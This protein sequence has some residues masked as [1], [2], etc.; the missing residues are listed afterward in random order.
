[1]LEHV[2]VSDRID[3]S[4]IVLI[5]AFNEAG[6]LGEVVARALRVA[7][8]V[9]VIDDG[10]TD[11]TSEVARSLG[12]EVVRHETNRGKG[13]SLVSGFARAVELGA[14]AVITLDADGQHPPE[15]IPR[16][17]DT[18]R[19]TGI[20]ILVGNRMA[21][22]AEMPVVRR[23]TNR[24]MS[25]WLSR[26]MGIYMPDTQCGFRLYRADVLAFAATLSPRFAMESEILLH[27]ARR[28]F[29]MGS[30]RIPTVYTGGKSRIRPLVD[31]FRFFSMLARYHH[32]QRQRRVD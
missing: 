31:A 25:A 8:Q 24:G 14:A 10:S 1:M 23:W 15:E 30:V 2:V 22:A 29:R 6:H 16:F 3:A 9:L 5:P 12:A 28:G 18:W 26:L 32:E 11:G 27:L 21:D 17:V 4:V 7:G 13:A 19:R 20:P